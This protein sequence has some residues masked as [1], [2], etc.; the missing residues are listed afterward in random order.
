MLDWETLAEDN[1]SKLDFAHFV[2]FEIR[3]FSQPAFPK[4]KNKHFKTVR[5]L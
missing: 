1:Y 2:T 3:I 5:F 4:M